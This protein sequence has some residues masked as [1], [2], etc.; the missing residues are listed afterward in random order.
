MFY[1]QIHLKGAQSQLQCLCSVSAVCLQCT[2][3]WTCSVHCKDTPLSTMAYLICCS[4]SAVS[5]QCLCSASE[6][7]KLTLRSVFAVYVLQCT[8]QKHCSSCAVCLQCFCSVSAVYTAEA[9][10]HLCS[11]SAVCTAEALQHLYWVLN[12]LKE[13]KMLYK[14]SNLASTEYSF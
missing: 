3:F 12:K 7:C 2:F 13:S 11:V 6:L 8:L 9:L 1:Q 4:V 14:Y 5:L 10:Q